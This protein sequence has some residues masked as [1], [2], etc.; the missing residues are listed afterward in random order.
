[1]MNNRPPNPSDPEAGFGLI[2]TDGTLT[3]QWNNLKLLAQMFSDPTL[4]RAP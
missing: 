4:R 3:P 1:M 2:N